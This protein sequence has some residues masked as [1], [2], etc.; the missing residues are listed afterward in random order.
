MGS[1]VSSVD[2]DVTT[3]LDKVSIFLFVRFTGALFLVFDSGT[4]TG[5]GTGMGVGVET[6]TFEILS[7]LTARDSARDSANVLTD[8]LGICLD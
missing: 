6:G 2:D 1:I 7:L 3:G 4:G 8:F 5:T